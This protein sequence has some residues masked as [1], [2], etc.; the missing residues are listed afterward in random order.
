MTST[1]VALLIALITTACTSEPATLT[2]SVAIVAPGVSAPD[3]TAGTVQP[4]DSTPPAAGSSNPSGSPTPAPWRVTEFGIG[5]L[6]A[7]MTVPEAARTVGGSFA[8]PASGAES[9]TYAVWR[10][11]PSGVRVML[12][13]GLVARVDVTSGSTATSRGVRI[14]DSETRVLDQYRGRTTVTPHKY[15]A[16]SHYITV[17]PLPGSGE[18]RSY[19]L[20]FETD[21]NRVTR[22]R[23]G[24]QPAVEYVE[25]C[26]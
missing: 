6:R 15:T 10:E 18:D 16:G 9:C 13:G 25:S 3:S 5:P 14:G 4:A 20:V 12:E 8:A 23:G 17:T 26:G 1:R 2:D 19:R 11:A 21:G 22:Y 24:R 7:G